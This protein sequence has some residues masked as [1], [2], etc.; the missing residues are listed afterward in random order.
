LHFGLYKNDELV[1]VVSWFQEKQTSL[2]RKF[3]TVVEKQNK[4]YGTKLINYVIEYS[5]SLGIKILYCNASSSLISFYSRFGFK[6]TNR[7]YQHDGEKFV[8]ME[9][10]LL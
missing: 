9:L 4:G 10:D 7:T 3:G 8:V 5:R 6:A 1:S 2:L